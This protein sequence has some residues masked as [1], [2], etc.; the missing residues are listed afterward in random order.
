[1]ISVDINP[2]GE[3]LLRQLNELEDGLKIKAL[4]SGLVRAVKPIKAHAKANAPADTGKLRQAIGHVQLSGRA[5]QRM[6]I[7]SSSLAILVGA[8]R[9]IDGEWQG[10]KQIWHEF[11]TAKMSAN[12]FLEK[13]LQ[14]GESGFEGRFYQGLS[15]YLN[16]LNKT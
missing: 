1:V 10:R 4:R 3:L 12:P 8:N 9:R 5:K 2:A 15:S 7:K 13:A 16:K 14:Y 6:G 11:G